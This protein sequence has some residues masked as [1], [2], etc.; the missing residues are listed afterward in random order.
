MNLE[1]YTIIPASA[2]DLER[3]LPDILSMRTGQDPIRPGNPHPLAVEYRDE[4]LANLAAAFGN[5]LDTSDPQA[6]TRAFRAGITSAQFSAGLEL[7]G[8]HMIGRAFRQDDSVRKLCRPL[9]VPDF[10]PR[11]RATVQVT[12]LKQGVENSELPLITGHVH[13]RVDPPLMTWTGMVLL[14]RETLI[15]NDA[16]LVADMFGE[17]GEM[18]QR[19]EQ[20]QVFTYLDSNPELP[21]LDGR[22][23]SARAWFTADDGNLLTGQTLNLAG[24]SAA[25]AAL[26]NQQGQDGHPA[27][28]NPAYLVVPT[29]SETTARG[30]VHDNGLPLELLV[31]PFI[32]AGRFYVAA[33]HEERPAIGLQFLGDP[34]D[35]IRTWS[36]SAARKLPPTMEGIGHHVNQDLRPVA[37]SRRGIVRI[38]LT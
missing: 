22:G 28:A 3:A 16:Q 18:L 4:H 29:E 19:N 32:A 13:E 31:S 30:L 34:G 33:R 17:V 9:P 11:N 10:K 38:E 6:V 24:L 5:L 20:R 14:S 36:V 37:V 27:N 23:G 1:H 7:T 21:E 25:T 15:N 35:Q 8:R 12:G 26:R 2:R